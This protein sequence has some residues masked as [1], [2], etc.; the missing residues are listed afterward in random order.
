MSAPSREEIE[1]QVQ[2]DLMR[3][4][5]YRNQLSQMIQQHQMLAA[6]RA[7]HLRARE[8]LHGLEAARD[9]T[10]VLLPLGGEAYIHGRPDRSGPVFLGIGAG[11]VAELDRPRAA[12]RLAERTKQIE[13]AA[14]DLEAQI[15]QVEERMTIL[16]RRV[17][18]LEARSA[19]EPVQGDVGRH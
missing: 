17:E 16:R 1:Q 14:R 2:E 12:E 19:G 10:D 3:L 11:Y 9:D 6:S 7:D 18:S 8:A 13:T 5:A 15:L 4:D